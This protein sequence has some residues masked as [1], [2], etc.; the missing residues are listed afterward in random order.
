M[1]LVY[2]AVD[3]VD[4]AFVEGH[5]T[6]KGLPTWR[7][8]LHD[9]LFSRTEHPANQARDPG[10]LAPLIDAGLVRAG[11]ELRHTQHRKGI[12]LHAVV[13]DDGH[14]ETPDGRRF[15]QPSPALKHLVGH[16]VNGWKSWTVVRHGKTLADL[17]AALTTG[18][19]P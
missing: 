16:E 1:E 9:I 8:A 2:P 13:T 19:Q 5:R 14:V 10:G 12:D 17:R 18:T 4:F 3:P 6:A 15:R 7:A 11:E